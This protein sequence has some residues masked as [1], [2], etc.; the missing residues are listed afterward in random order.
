MKRIWIVGSLGHMGQALIKLLDMLE[1]ELYETDKEEVD[2]TNEAEVSLFMYRNRP[3]VVINCAGFSGYD[4]LGKPDVDMAYKV[5]AVGARNLAQ[6][7]ESIQAKLIQISTDD[8][9]SDP[10]DTPY[11]EFDQVNPQGIFAKSKYA[12]EKFVTQLMTRY[13]IIRSSWIYGI[14]QDFLDE[15]LEAAADSFVTSLTLKDN[16]RAIPTSAEELAR[17]VMLFIDADHF[18]TYHAV[19]SGDSCTRLE[20][21]REI[22][23]LAGKEDSLTLS[24]AEN[25]T[26][27]YSV[28]DNMMLR[29]TGLPQP[30]DWR[31]VLKAFMQEQS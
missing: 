4:A 17:I 1:Y 6:A 29:I 2:I 26:Q 18:G 5:N 11:N 25:A 30:A 10:S 16:S 22:L 20:F 27:K 12:G 8:V 3:D 9:F 13:V 23:R 28:L 7:A 19:C 21:A 15:V 31:E 14:G 24:V